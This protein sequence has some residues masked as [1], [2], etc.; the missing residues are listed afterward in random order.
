MACGS[1]V[2]FHFLRLAEP[3]VRLSTRMSSLRIEQREK[4]ALVSL[5]VSREATLGLGSL[6]ANPSESD[7]AD[8]FFCT[9]LCKEGGYRFRNGSNQAASEW[10]HSDVSHS[11]CGYSVLAVFPGQEEP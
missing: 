3:L 2:G 6:R 8:L 10:H 9:S 11:E 7:I 5:H 4:R 1:T